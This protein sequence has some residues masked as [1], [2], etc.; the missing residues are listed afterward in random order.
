MS[1]LVEFFRLLGRPC[2]EMTAVASQTL[3]HDAPRSHRLAFRIHTLY[4]KACRRYMAQLRL[5]RGAFRTL[6]AQLVAGGPLPGPTLSPAARARIRQALR[7][8]A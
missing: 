8:G 2:R 4:C 6:A 7:G 5:L 1:G 3:D